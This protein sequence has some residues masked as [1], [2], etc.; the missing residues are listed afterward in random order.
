ME[1]DVSICFVRKPWSCFP[2]WPLL[3]W[4]NESGIVVLSRC[5]FCVWGNKWVAL[6]KLWYFS[7]Q[8]VWQYEMFHTNNCIWWVWNKITHKSYNYLKIMDCFIS[9]H[10]Y[11][12][13]KCIWCSKGYLFRT[14]IGWVT[15]GFQPILAGNGLIPSQSTLYGPSWC[16]EVISWCG[17][18]SRK[19]SR[20]GIPIIF[21]PFLKKRTFQTFSLF[22][23][24]FQ[25]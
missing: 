25:M 4:S 21:E 10:F 19:A 15:G 1:V 12:N 2:P 22:T 14:N 6:L 7:L 16:Q 3:A 13:S 23:K 9:F 11:Q 17:S 5:I 20:Q 24:V 18:K 8:A